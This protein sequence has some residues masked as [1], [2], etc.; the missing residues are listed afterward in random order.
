MSRPFELL[1]IRLLRY[2]YIEPITN[3]WIW[4]GA[5]HRNGY[6]KIGIEGRTEQVHR[7]SA[8]VW[9][10]FDLKSKLR[11]LHKNSCHRRNCFNPDH[12]YVGNQSRNIL[13]AVELG[14]QVNARKTHCPQG[15]EYTP[16]NTILE[17]KLFG[18]KTR[19][20][21]ICNNSRK[22]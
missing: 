22:R 3:C 16:E 19:H 11:V 18:R 14:T 21:K 12:L 6:G 2:R 10:N 17:I 5:M 13:D 1:D 20:C 15:H 7:A 4:T 8:H 9:L